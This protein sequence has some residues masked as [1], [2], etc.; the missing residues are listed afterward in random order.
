LEL[1]NIELEKLPE[2]ISDYLKTGFD[3]ADSDLMKFTVEAVRKSKIKNLEVLI[4]FANIYPGSESTL[5]REIESGVYPLSEEA[6]TRLAVSMF[7]YCRFPKKSGLMNA[8][9]KT[10]EHNLDLLKIAF[11]SLRV[12][13]EDEIL[14][15]LMRRMHLGKHVIS[16]I[17]FLIFLENWSELKDYPLDWSIPIIEDQCF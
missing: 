5:I 11:S 7:H 8:S 14:A 15:E 1:S 17:S 16:H 10:I 6:F 13:H 9:I 4:A 2:D 3:L 12:I